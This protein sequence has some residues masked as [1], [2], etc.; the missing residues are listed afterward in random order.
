MSALF[1]TTA[2]APAALACAVEAGIGGGGVE[3]DLGGRRLGAQRAAQREA[4][5]VAQ[6]PVEQHDVRA[7]VAQGGEQLV[8]VARGADAHEAGLGAQDSLEPSAQNGMVVDDENPD[9][10]LMMLA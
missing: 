6:P 9:H 5:L 3:H 7:G 2:W 1:S 8:A 10:V 4:V